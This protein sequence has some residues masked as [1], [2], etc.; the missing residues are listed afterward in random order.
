MDI[1]EARRYALSLPEA[2]EAPHFKA[3]S[4]RI[5]GKIFATVPP[6]GEYLHIFVD[7]MRRDASIAMFPEYCEKLWWGKKAIGIRVALSAADLDEV[8]DL[9]IAAWSLKAPKKLLKSFRDDGAL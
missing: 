6:D 2:T 4:F 3:S 7:E 8:K 9:L 1:D 5:R